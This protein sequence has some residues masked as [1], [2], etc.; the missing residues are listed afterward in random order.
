MTQVIIL[1]NGTDAGW[2]GHLGVRKQLIPVDGE[3][4]LC[5]TVRQLTE[6]GVSSLTIA[7]SHR[8]LEVPGADIFVPGEAPTYRNSHPPGLAVSPLFVWS[9]QPTILLLG[10]V[11]YSDA[12]MDT[13]VRPVDSW[14]FYCRFGPTGPDSQPIGGEGWAIQFNPADLVQYLSVLLKLDD[15]AIPGQHWWQQ[16]RMMNGADPLVHRVLG[17]PVIIDD[18]TEDF[19][20]PSD[21]D[22]WLSRHPEHHI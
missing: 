4:I 3:P 10:D 7:T 2:N 22:R 9:D 18:E 11:R 14:T 19:D 16:Y 6:R 21:L 15:L 20:Y 17:T 1:C 12:A 8:E 5:R 13:I